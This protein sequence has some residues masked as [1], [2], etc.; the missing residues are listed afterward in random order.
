[1]M[2]AAQHKG[3]FDRL[4][5]NKRE[6]YMARLRA[7][8]DLRA[9]LMHRPDN[10]NYLAL[11]RNTAERQAMREGL[12]LLDELEKVG[13]V[14]QTRNEALEE[15][16]AAAERKAGQTKI[17]MGANPDTGT[18]IISVVVST[19]RLKRGMLVTVLSEGAS[20]DSDAGQLAELWEVKMEGN[21]CM[22]KAFRVDDTNA[23]LRDWETTTGMRT[24]INFETDK[25]E[26]LE[27]IGPFHLTSSLHLFEQDEENKVE[28]Y[29]A[30]RIA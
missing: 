10:A 6:E 29:D 16:L 28:S 24:A 27:A 12:A 22:F 20:A 26:T 23:K 17:A 5:A 1:M 30:K 8:T 2:A 4:L 3:V 15:K 25:P 18:F 14:L 11:E 19:R 13:G 21:K 9:H 7:A